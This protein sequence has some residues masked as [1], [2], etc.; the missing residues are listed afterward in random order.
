MPQNPS[1]PD[2]GEVPGGL[3]DP[4]SAFVPL[5][6]DGGVAFE[7]TITRDT[8]IIINAAEKKTCNIKAGTKVSLIAKNGGFLR[9]LGDGFCN[10]ETQSIEG[11]VPENDLTEILPESPVTAGPSSETLPG[12]GTGSGT[13]SDS[14]TTI[15]VPSSSATG[16]SQVQIVTYKS[17][18]IIISKTGASNFGRDPNLANK[19]CGKGLKSCVFPGEWFRSPSTYKNLDLKILGEAP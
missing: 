13:D 16:C 14:T 18:H 15:H 7:A 5:L 1:L 2:F 17:P 10:G 8:S 11:F 4:K 19:P 9:V 6:G 3:A 12:S